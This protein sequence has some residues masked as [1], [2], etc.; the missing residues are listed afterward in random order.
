MGKI[1]RVL[2]G[3][4]MAT[5]LIGCGGGS[6]GSGGSGGNGGNGGNGGDG[7]ST[8]GVTHK[9]LTI[10]TPL[11]GLTVSLHD[12][13]NHLKKLETK[14][15]G[16]DGSV[17][18]DVDS[19]TVTASVSYS[20]KI[21]V[22]PDL[23]FQT[24]KPQ[25]VYYAHHNCEYG[26]LNMSECKSADWCAIQENNTTI[27]AWV[28]D[29]AFAGSGEHNIT[30]ANTDTNKDG[31]ISVDEFYEAAKTMYDKD[32]NDAITI[33]ELFKLDNVYVST[34]LFVNVPVR[35]Y[36]IRMSGGPYGHYGNGACYEISKFNLNLIH[37]EHTRAFR[38]GGSGW[39]GGQNKDG[40]STLSAKVDIGHPDTQGN[41]DYLVVMKDE[42]YTTIHTEAL[43]DQTKGDLTDGVT[44]DVPT[45]DAP[46]MK[47]VTIIKD[48]NGTSSFFLRG[49]YNGIDFGYAE[50]IGEDENKSVIKQYY[51]SKLTYPIG[52]RALKRDGNTSL[53]YQA[54]NDY[55]GDGKLKNIYKFSDYPML[56]VSVDFS[57]NGVQF[58]G[59]EVGKIDISTFVSKSHF[60][61]NTSYEIAAFG[62][63]AFRIDGGDIKP[64][65]L[66]PS[67]L[68][69]LMS[70]DQNITHL[71]AAAIE[72]KSQDGMTIFKKG[73]S[74][75]TYG[76]V[77]SVYAEQ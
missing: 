23:I 9:T 25:L 3:L 70:G 34:R 65:N 60:D 76:P 11:P 52:V 13:D 54:Y 45:L 36:N 51:N 47:E 14:T 28:V 58:A 48:I 42:N 55:Y 57:G 73:L 21:E 53:Y 2:L 5:L 63:G 67:E 15:T 68:S 37:A 35:T 7:G 27:P 39:G 8:G 49:I 41:Y 6:G 32:K 61:N 64:A 1:Y 72:D 26:D 30:A 56:N 29:A 19:D 33:R 4:G 66:L 18:F 17:S 38:V 44:Y 62:T 74:R 22:T 16:S 24:K 71:S 43:L 69:S 50:R 40:N 77:R 10:H 75:E 46:S 31:E 20:T 59:N 12:P